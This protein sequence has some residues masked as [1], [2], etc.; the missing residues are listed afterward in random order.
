MNDCIMKGDQVVIPS[1]L[2]TQVLR[3][4]HQ[5]HLGIVKMKQ[6]ARNYCWWPT[7][8]RDI[9]HVTQSCHVCRKCQSLPNPQYHSWEEPEQVWSRIHVDFAGPIWNTKWLIIVDAK[10]KFP[11][12]IDMQNNTTATNLIQALEQVFDFVGPPETIISDNGPPFNSFQM[13][14]FYEKYDISHITTAPYHPASNGLAERFVRSFKEGMLKQQNLG[15]SNKSIA[16]RNV[17]RSYRW[18]PH[19]STGSSPANLLFRHSIRTEFDIMKPTSSSTTTSLQEPKFVVGQLVWTLKY[20][21]N[22][23]PQ[24]DNAFILKPIG[25]MLYEV[26]LSTGQVCKR[27]QNQLRPYYSSQSAPSTSDSLLSDLT[28]PPSKPTPTTNCSSP[29]TP[30]YPR[31]NRHTPVRYSPS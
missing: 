14:K 5:D 25:S 29:S 8:N 31:R 4:L 24:W 20:Q 30:R 17:L 1:E 6:I 9:K 13:S 21:H 19:T 15:Y 28:I 26:R 22:H 11:F 3:L 18:S 16:L 10:S 7:I 2:Q 12:V 23:R 27:H